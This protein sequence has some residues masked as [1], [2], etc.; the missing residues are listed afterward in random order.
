MQKQNLTLNVKR[1]C[2][3]MDSIQ[4]VSTSLIEELWKYK[5]DFEDLRNSI[6]NF[7]ESKRRAGDV[8]ESQRNAAIITINNV[9]TY[10]QGKKVG[11]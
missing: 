11:K 7:K 1:E 6:A 5:S 2:T 8:E 9:I 10:R 3:A 4:E